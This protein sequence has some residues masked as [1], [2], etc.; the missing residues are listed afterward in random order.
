MKVGFIGVGNMG[1]PMC[2]NIVK[3]SNHQVTVFDLN[4]SAVKACTDLGATAG[5]SIADATSGADVVMTSLPMPKDVEAVTLGERG[6]LA[7]I[8][9][10]QTYIDL[11]TNA[12]S[13]VKKIG[14][15]MAAK[16]IAMLDAPVSGGTTGAEAATIAIMVGGDRK[17][18]DDALP[19]LQSFSANVIHMGGLGTGTVAKL[20][21]NM[22]SYCNMAALSEG[23][24]L[25]TRYGLDPDKL[26]HVIASSSGNS[27]AIKNFTLRALPGKYSPPSFALDLAYKDLHLAL[28][29]GD[30]L[31]IPLPQGS[32]THTLQRLARGMGFGGDDS[33]S[34]L[35]VYE[36]MLNHKVKP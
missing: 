33:S 20:V 10:G 32:S 17:V 16:G 6:I 24:M 14:A 19:V 29:L 28:E 22:L 21:N 12:P 30:E 9:P 31:G 36:K 27:N 3:R 2:R 4:A 26:L 1:G 18:F 8:K 34:V 7:S 13:M 25:G 35:R 11:S 15:A 23:M 5:Q